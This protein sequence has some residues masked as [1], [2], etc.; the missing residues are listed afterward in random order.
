MPLPPPL[1]KQHLQ[2]PPKRL[3]TKIDKLE[4]KIRMYEENLAKI[5]AGSSENLDALALEKARGKLAEIH[6]SV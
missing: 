5:V 4:A 1:P 3:V 2:L 6:A